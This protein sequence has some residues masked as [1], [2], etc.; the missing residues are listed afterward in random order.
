VSDKKE[1]GGGR[2]SVR[3]VAGA[4]LIAGAVLLAATAYNNLGQQARTL[5]TGLFCTLGVLVT[6]VM[7]VVLIRQSGGG[8]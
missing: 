5:V 4:V 6:I 7:L 2:I 3:T 8:D 1:P